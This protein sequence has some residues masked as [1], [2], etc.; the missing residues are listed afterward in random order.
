[1]YQ[2]GLSQESTAS[3]QVTT[4]N[5]IS[6][7]LK[8]Y[9]KI[10][11]YLPKNYHSS[12]KKFPV[13]YLQDAQNLF[14]AKTSFAG[15][16]NIDE[17]LDSLKAEVIVVGIEHGNE[18]RLDELTPYH[19]EKYGGGRADDYLDFIIT[20]VK[21]YI[22]K[23]FRVK[24]SPKHTTIGGSSLGGLFSLYALQKHPNAFQKGI[25]FSPAFWINP[26]LFP[27]IEKSNLKAK[28]YFLC[29]EKEGEEMVT[30][31]QKMITILPKNCT[32]TSEIIKDGQHNEK[33]WREAFAKA[34]LWLYK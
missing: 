21:P 11:I 25:I 29:G 9:K 32:I 22:E 12:K 20:Q 23:N 13:I 15:E 4:I 14:D 30:D 17:T 2:N 6:P 10:W 18:K 26:E 28:M 16:W 31:M 24:S 27:V 8:T 1:M 3:K 5:I 19:H 34:Y 33:L 7:Q